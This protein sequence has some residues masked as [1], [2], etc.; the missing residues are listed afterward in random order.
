MN[1]LIN[2]YDNEESE[3]LN[4]PSKELKMNVA[5]AQFTGKNWKTNE[6]TWG[7]LDTWERRGHELIR[8]YLND[9]PVRFVEQELKAENEELWHDGLR[10]KEMETT[11]EMLRMGKKISHNR[12]QLWEDGIKLEPWISGRTG[13][14][15]RGIVLRSSKFENDDEKHHHELLRHSGMKIIKVEPTMKIIWKILEKD[16]WLMTIHSYVKFENEFENNSG[17]GLEESGKILGK[18]LWVRTH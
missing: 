14:H 15:L 17:K 18:D 13:K 11:H 9:A 1:A 12:K 10:R 6:D 2:W 3:I 7:D 8:G 16:I 4:E 5:K